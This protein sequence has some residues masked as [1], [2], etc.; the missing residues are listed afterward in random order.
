MGVADVAQF[1][2]KR[3]PELDFELPPDLRT[4]VDALDSC[5]IQVTP[6]TALH[7][8]I[9]DRATY[10]LRF[11]DG[12]TL[13]GRTLNQGHKAEM[14][15]FVRNRMDMGSFSRV[16]SNNG[17]AVLEE[18]IDGIPLNQLPPRQQTTYRCGALLGKVH[19][20]LAVSSRQPAV[21]RTIR[22]LTADCRLPTADSPLRDGL[23]Q[24]KAI[25]V[26]S[27]SETNQLWSTA[28]K[29]RPE[30]VE[31]GF[32]H[33]DFCAENLVLRRG[34][35]CGIDNTTMSIGPL[36]K[37]LSRTWYRWPMSNR[38]WRFFLAGYGTRRSVRQYL[39]HA[40]YWAILVLVQASLFRIRALSPLVLVPL[41]RLSA[42][43]SDSWQRALG[44]A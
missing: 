10:F 11:D 28:R 6:I 1:G 24:L 12:T 40:P 32:V 25:D 17:Q 20:Q 39:I 23:D 37:D 5:L 26:L 33:R 3:R 14:M 15:R 43:H 31:I 41:R 35:P 9:P 16:L 44:A 2:L 29:Y 21:R 34:Q 19:R 4:L 30:S 27:Q 8:T 22:Q 7:T 18:W 42:F 13:K 38:Q 36:D